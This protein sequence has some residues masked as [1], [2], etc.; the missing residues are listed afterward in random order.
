MWSV[1]ENSWRK[2]CIKQIPFGL[3]REINWSLWISLCFLL[4]TPSI[5][6]IFFRCVSSVDRNRP[7]VKACKG[8]EGAVLGWRPSVG[9]P[10]ANPPMILYHLDEMLLVSPSYLFG[11]HS[12]S[13]AFVM[14]ISNPPPTETV[15]PEA[16]TLLVSVDHTAEPSWEPLHLHAVQPASVRRESGY[17]LKPG[18]RWLDWT[19]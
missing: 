8:S 15:L 19:G 3:N 4:D 1:S 11:L 14:V 18:L 7:D 12:L 5:A 2:P 13:A 17:P 6:I 10:S 9:L 16:H